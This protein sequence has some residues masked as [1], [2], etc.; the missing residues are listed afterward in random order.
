MSTLED[1]FTQFCRILDVGEKNL[2]RGDAES[3]VALAQIAARYAYP[4][5]VGLFASPRLERLLISIGQSLATPATPHGY[6]RPRHSQRVLHILSY[7]RPVGGDSR[8]VWRWIQEDRTNEHSVCVTSQAEVSEI[9]EM[10]PV[11]VRSVQ[12]SG[13]SLHILQAPTSRPLDQAVELRGLCQEMDIVVLH[14]FPYDVIPILALCTGCDTA[15]TIFVNHSDHTFWIGAS[16]AHLIV[17]LRSQQNNFLERRRGLKKGRDTLLPIP[18]APRPQQTSKAEAKAALG[19]DSDVVILLTIAS[20]FKYSSP[21]RQGLLELVVPLL[22]E[23]HQAVLLAVGPEPEG[24]W[25]EAGIRTEGRVV[26]LGARFDNDALYTAADVYLDSVPFSSITSLLEAGS[27]GVSLLG[28]SPPDPDLWLLGPGAPG[29]EG[30]MEMATDA[31]SYRCLLRRH[32]ADKDHRMVSGRRVRAQILA[33]H[34]GAGWRA[35]VQDVYSRVSTAGERGCLSEGADSCVAGPL[36]VALSQLYGQ[37]S[38]KSH[39]SRYKAPKVMRQWLRRLL[40]PLPYPK[41]VSIAWE[42]YQKEVG[43]SIISFLPSFLHVMARSLARSARRFKHLLSYRM[44]M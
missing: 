28:L 26:A 29:L 11:L 12:Q 42:L 14:H 17:H 20:P 13:G 24:A 44:R 41:R 31:E 19:Y 6:D 3:A 34:T 32:V 38:P 37:K 4:G 5:D 21:G 16:V 7:A 2:N 33:R 22:G 8:F 9:Y 15:R 18:L 27:C 43:L 35:A 1:S 25:R 30:T 36:N 40:Q 10:P 23:M 39:L